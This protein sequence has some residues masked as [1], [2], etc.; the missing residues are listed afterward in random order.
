MHTVT[1][2]T[3]LRGLLSGRSGHLT[4][5]RSGLREGRITQPSPSVTIRFRT[6]PGWWSALVPGG[7]AGLPREGQEH[8]A[9]LHYLPGGDPDRLHDPGT[10]EIGRAHV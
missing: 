1:D 10:F 8:L 6:P 7:A 9:F 4:L 2:F 3:G 5:G